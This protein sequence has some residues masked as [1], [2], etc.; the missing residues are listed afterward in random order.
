MPDELD[1]HLESAL[2]KDFRRL[3]ETARHEALV[4]GW[5][6][7][8]DSAW[9]TRVKDEVITP[10]LVEAVAA[11]QHSRLYADQR[12]RNGGSGARLEAGSVDSPTRSTL[13][14]DLHESGIRVES[15]ESGF[16]E[17]WTDR[18]YVSETVV[19]EKVGDFL[20]AVA[21]RYQPGQLR[22]GI[23]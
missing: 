13:I 6:H 12:P 4:K 7:L 19:T 18:A 3:I 8:S 10:I 14:F 17:D 2:R 15:S 23:R 22:S 5:S 9:W 11:L 21:G 16:N 1:N 20:K